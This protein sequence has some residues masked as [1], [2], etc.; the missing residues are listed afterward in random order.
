M[1]SQLLEESLQRDID[2]I[3]DKVMEMAGL[4]ETALRTSLQ[5][6]NEKNQQLAYSVILRDRYIDELE[7]EL[8]LLCQKFLVRHQPAAGHLRFVYAT[9]KINNEL[10]R[11][12]DYAESIARHFLDL[13]AMEPFPNYKRFVEI[14]NLSIPML[15]NAMQAFVDQNMDLANAT[16]ELE[17]KVDDLRYSVTQDLARLRDSGQI[18]SEALAPLTI[19]ASRFERV[20]DQAC[21][22]CEEVLFMGTGQNIKHEGVDIF[23][24]LFV[25]ATN[26][27][28]SQMAEGIGKSLGLDSVIFN[29]AGIAPEPIDSRTVR[30]L[31]EK[32]IDISKQNSKYLNEIPEPEAY[33]VIISL[34]KEADIAFPAPPTKTVSISWHIG[35]PSKLKGTEQKI[36]AAYEK[37]YDYLDKNIRSLIDAVLIDE[38]EEK[39]NVS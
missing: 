35:D 26:S 5:A 20:A 11:I 23:R 34:S 22:I 30:F 19:I 32:G 2:Q 36:H 14:A 39:K 4:A 15:R 6:I 18:T 3:K 37:T 29:S 1:K 33:Q 12:G 8:D 17:E 25:D 28:V 27:C 16:I 31:S 24:V 38:K 13:C 9:I 10:E 21:N 7:K